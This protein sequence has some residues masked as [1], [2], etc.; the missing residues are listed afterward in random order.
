MCQ[1][2][3][4]NV[5]KRLEDGAVNTEFFALHQG[6]CQCLKKAVSKKTVEDMAAT[7]LD[8]CTNICGEGS[9]DQY[10]GGEK[11]GKF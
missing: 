7:S 10:C 9:Y 2:W 1:N 11:D 8:Y 5:I 3:C 6:E 4:K